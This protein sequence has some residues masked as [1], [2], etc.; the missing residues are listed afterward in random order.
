MTADELARLRAQWVRAWR[1][2]IQEGAAV[3]M[4]LYVDLICGAKG[5]RTGK[6]CQSRTLYWS[7][8]CRHHGG[9]STGPIT[10]QGLAK[11]LQNLK[12]NAR[13]P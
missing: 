1:A 2:Y 13:T 10:E 8:R 4:L 7:G 6:P 3:D 5:K 12:C 9:L 11:S